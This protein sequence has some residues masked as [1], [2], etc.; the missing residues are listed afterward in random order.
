[1]PDQLQRITLPQ[2]TAAVICALIWAGQAIALK[3]SLE[4]IPAV[5]TMALRFL[6]PLPL[7]FAVA[8]Y[9]KIPIMP[10]GREW[11]TLVINAALLCTQ[12]SLFTYG[13]DLTDST[14][15]VVLI[16][17]FPFFAA[18]AGHFFLT[19][20][21][22][23]L[24]VLIGI[25]LSFAGVPI[26]F[27]VGDQLASSSAFRGNLLVLAA[28]AVMGS[29]IIFMKRALGTIHPVKLALWD[30]SAAAIFFS[31]SVASQP[32]ALDFSWSLRSFAAIAYQGWVVSLI[33]FLLWLS[34][35][36][37][38]SANQLNVFRLLTPPAGVI[39]GAI[40]LH[41][42]TSSRLLICLVAVCIGLYL[43]LTKKPNRSTTPSIEPPGSP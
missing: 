40:I 3:I 4:D 27:G 34:L 30:V 19:G 41:E 26:L 29:K 8:K 6:L 37:K 42:P 18:I 12:I 5:T 43:V 9:K 1:M 13:T 17:T 16:N 32:G 23:T 25:A 21:R 33:G 28:A 7:L 2:A 15:S 35:L 31:V 24:R 39:L 38:H 22:L 20:H 10:H 36:S 11:W 14:A